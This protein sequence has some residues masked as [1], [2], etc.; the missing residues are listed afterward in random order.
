MMNI[1]NGIEYRCNLDLK[2]LEPKCMGLL[3]KCVK[4]KASNLTRFTFLRVIRLVDESPGIKNNDTRYY[5][6]SHGLPHLTALFV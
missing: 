4:P 3:V 6:S 1:Y 2:I 5:D